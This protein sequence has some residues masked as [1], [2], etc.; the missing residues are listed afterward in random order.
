MAGRID[1]SM[2]D[3][4]LSMGHVGLVVLH[5]IGDRLVSVNIVFCSLI[6]AD[7]NHFVLC[8]L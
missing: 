7:T 6:L 4:N 3:G 2:S 5:P 1:S 8:R